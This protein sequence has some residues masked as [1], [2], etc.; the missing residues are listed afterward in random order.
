MPIEFGRQVCGSLSE[1]SAR[2]WLVTDGLGGYAMGTVAGLRTRRYHGLLMVAGERGRRRRRGREPAHARSRRARSDS[3][4]RRSPHPARHRRVGEWCRRPRR[5][6]RARVVHAHTR[7]PEVAMGDR[8]HHV[9]TRDR[10][11]ARST[12]GRR[13]VTGWSTPRARCGSSSLRC[14]RGETATATVTPAADP[15]VEAVPTASSSSTRTACAAPSWIAGGSWYRGVRARAEAE[16]GLG[17]TE[18]LWAAGCF[19]TLLQ[20]GECADV[21]AWAG[22]LDRPPPP[23]AEIVTSAQARAA[24]V[25]AMARPTD[26]VD[27]LLARAADQFVVTTA[28]GPSVVAGYPWFG[29]WSRDTMTSY[30]GLFLCAGRHEEG[31][32][33]LLRSAATLSEGM[34]ANT[35]DAGGLEYN[36]ADGT[37]WFIHAVGRHV[38]VTGDLDLA[39]QARRD[40][41]RHHRRAL[42]RHSVRHQGRS[43]RRPAAAGCARLGIDVDGRARRRATDHGARRQGGR[44]QRAVGQRARH[45]ER[46]ASPTRPARR[47]MA[48]ARGV[49]SVVVPH[50]LRPPRPSPRR[51]RHD[52]HRR[53]SRSDRTSCSPCRSPTARSRDR[54][55]AGPPGSDLAV[56][57]GLDLP[58]R[59]AHLARPALAVASR[60]R[61]HRP[62][63]R[64][65]GRARCAPTTRA[66]CGRG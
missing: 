10:D 17:D 34:L 63:P 23:A 20:P 5:L 16:R 1:A 64:R 15:S 43:E 55:A 14:A 48:V 9:R 18:D 24:R 59:P 13:D 52:G 42:A 49:R 47:S 54:P 32:D 61:L 22:D 41:R 44:H 57:R 29:E 25:E 36:T 35:A 11:G 8:R 21:V 26:E 51:G 37:L 33:L 53:R 2:E 31:R 3:G 39:R 45:G 19:A 65:T 28:T 58:I 50:A 12:R 60:S 56:G 7:D 6:R 46:P 27:A 30:E 38:A 40:A 4:R 62:P 66:R